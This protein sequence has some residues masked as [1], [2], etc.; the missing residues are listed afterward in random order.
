MLASPLYRF[1]ASM[2][3]GAPGDPGVYALW[4]KDELIF[5]GRADGHGAT[6]QS[7]LME[8]YGGKI[9]PTSATHYSWELSR[10][11][12]AREAELLRNFE[13]RYQRRPRHN[14]AA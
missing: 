5:I 14:K 6:I 8:H 10:N 12:A 4:D 9:E 1:T 2:I 7:M 3:S 13:A 11:P